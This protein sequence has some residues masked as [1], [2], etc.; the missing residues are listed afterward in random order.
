MENTISFNS[1]FGLISATEIDNKI[2]KIK[3]SKKKTRGRMTK[4]LKNLKKKINLYF[5]N[6]TDKIEVKIRIQGNLVQK[7]VW[8]QLRKI[9]KGQTKS[10]GEIAKK[11]RI[12]PRYVGKICGENRHI[13]VIP[14][15]RILRSNGALGG[16]SAPGGIS[17]K[18]KLLKFEGLKFK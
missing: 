2:T 6:K 18:K 15:H 16:F 3:F 12:S 1:K 9:K 11:L 13:L 4:V 7:K 8:K 10:Y 5:Q 17:L 14:C